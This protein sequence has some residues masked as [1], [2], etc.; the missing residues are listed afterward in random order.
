MYFLKLRKMLRVLLVEISRIHI[1]HVVYSITVKIHALVQS[2]HNFMWYSWGNILIS[3]LHFHNVCFYANIVICIGGCYVDFRNEYLSTER[4]TN[5]GVHHLFIDFCTIILLSSSCQCLFC[6][7]Y[8]TVRKCSHQT[9][10]TW[11]YQFVNYY[12]TCV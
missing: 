5:K 3:S 11:T 6:I 7:G 12:T 9:I 1:A 8:A 10:E 4:Y 2:Q